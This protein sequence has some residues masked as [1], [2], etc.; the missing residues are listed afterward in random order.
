MCV[1]GMDVGCFGVAGLAESLDGQ[2]EDVKRTYAARTQFLSPPWKEQLG[3]CCKACWR[4]AV[5]SGGGG[6][7]G[8]GG[9]G[10]G[11]GGGERSR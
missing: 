2:K 11:G 7:F 8:V 3:C 1:L 6:V 9:G 10:G 5:M 4:K